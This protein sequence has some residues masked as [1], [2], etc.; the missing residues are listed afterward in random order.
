MNQK[1]LEEELKKHKVDLDR[2]LSKKIRESSE[3]KTMEIL[4]VAVEKEDRNSR[5]TR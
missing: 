2:I 3:K 1:K 5:G 4:R